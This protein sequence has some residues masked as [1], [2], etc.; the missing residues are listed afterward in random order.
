MLVKQLDYLLFHLVKD[1]KY[2]YVN[3]SLKIKC[4][5]FL[6]R[7]VWMEPEIMSLRCGKIPFKH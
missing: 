7:T 4:K 5:N 3:W 2:Y 1:R 6:P